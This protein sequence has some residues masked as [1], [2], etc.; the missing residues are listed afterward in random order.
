MCVT[1]ANTLCNVGPVV[2]LIFGR[3]PTR[4]TRP[5]PPGL[6]L[7]QITCSTDIRLR[8]AEPENT[9]YMV[10]R[11]ATERAYT[12]LRNSLTSAL[13]TRWK[14]RFEQYQGSALRR[15]FNKSV[16]SSTVPKKKQ[17][18]SSHCVDLVFALN[19]PHELPNIFERLFRWPIEYVCM[20]GLCRWL[21]VVSEI[22]VTYALTTLH[23]PYLV[24]SLLVYKCMLSARRRGN[25]DLCRPEATK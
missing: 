11:C 23:H 22:A 1:P 3:V 13:R 2:S 15:P 6:K 10:Q 7:Q 14:R 18:Q 19:F 12:N 16:R 5:V 8:A 20:G 24:V 9:S 21:S 4:P 17:R 25:S